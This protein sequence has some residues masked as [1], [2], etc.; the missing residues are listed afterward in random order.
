MRRRVGIF[1]ATD[2]ALALIPLLAANPGIEIARV[3]DDDAEA[4]V[5]RFPHLE[6]GVAA[7]LELTLTDDPTA[8]AEDTSLHAV[9]DTS[10]ARDFGERYPQVA[11]RGV[12]LVTPLTAR[13]LWG[14]GV[15]RTEHKADLLQALHE[16]VEGYN[17][18]ID[19]DELFTRMLEISLGVTG[20]EGGSLMLLDEERGDLFVRV[21]QVE[22]GDA[23]AGLGGHEATQL[24]ETL[25]QGARRVHD[26]AHLAHGGVAGR[27]AAQRGMLLGA[28]D[29]LG[30]ELR[31]L[32]GELEVRLRERLGAGRY[33][34]P[35]Y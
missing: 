4:I 16:V 30:V 21:V 18:T 15:A 25:G 6:S 1:G 2:E 11:A 8:L 24:A 20:A 22:R 33:A 29:D 7:L 12:Q 9:I 3:Q 34:I 31:E 10:T 5:R 17:L 28:R 14:Y 35:R 23:P 27:L 19:A 32:L 26:R 13:L